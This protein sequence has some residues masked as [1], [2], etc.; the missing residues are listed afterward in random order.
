M[1]AIEKTIAYLDK[2]S[3]ESIP[4]LSVGSCL[5]V[6]SASDIPIKVDIDLLRLERQPK[7]ET[8]NLNKAWQ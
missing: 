4:F 8:I 2:L 1:K 7:S 6:E 5:I 3:F